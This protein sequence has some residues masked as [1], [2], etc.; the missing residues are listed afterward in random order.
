MVDVAIP[1]LAFLVVCLPV[2][3]LL[4][5]LSAGWPL[6]ARLSVL[7]VYAL[8][9]LDGRRRRLRRKRETFHDFAG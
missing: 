1:V 9:L 4:W 8:G 3:W 6:A 5:H 2:G 7:G